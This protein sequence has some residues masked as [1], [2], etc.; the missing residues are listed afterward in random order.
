[1]SGVIS[2]GL[3]TKY[4]EGSQGSSFNYQLSVLQL[5]DA[6]AGSSGCCPTAATEATLLQVL[7]AIQSGQDYEAKLV[8]DANDVVWLEV[9]IW[10]IV[11]HTFD[12][13][14]YYAAGSNVPG[15][16]VLPIT[17]IDPTTYLAQIVSNTSAMATDIAAIES[18]IDVPLSDLAQE[19]TQLQTNIILRS[20]G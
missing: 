17:Y 3:G 19:S 9:R 6:I 5:L 18:N 11:T 7:T 1:M 14:I 10:N 2:G 4:K 12:P 20:P 15:A 13:P 16:P 8:R